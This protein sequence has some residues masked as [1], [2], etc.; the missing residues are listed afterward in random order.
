MSTRQHRRPTVAALRLMFVG[1]LASGCASEARQ[2]EE[3]K[4]TDSVS[5]YEIFLAAY[6][7]GVYADSARREVEAIHFEEAKAENSLSGYETFLNLYPDGVYADSARHQIV[8][9]HFEEA[10]AASSIAGFHMFLALYPEG[11]HAERARQLL[12]PLYKAR[13]ERLFSISE[14][15]YLNRPGKPR[16]LYTHVPT[17]GSNVLRNKDVAWMNLVVDEETGREQLVFTD[18]A[19]GD[20]IH[21]TDLDAKGRL[22]DP[23][24]LCLD[25][26][27]NVLR[28]AGKPVLVKPF[29]VE[30]LRKR[31]SMMSFVDY[32]PYGRPAKRT[33]AVWPCVNCSAQTGIADCAYVWYSMVGSQ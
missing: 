17:P 16:L 22:K 20:V 13:A 31:G 6:P 7:E 4:A 11:K 14:V 27:G 21:R 1:L 9:I 29:E 23:M 26:G 19:S 18:A 2:W 15:V 30:V 25:E 10:R 28:K 12:E 8:A 5:A 24:M 32:D 33:D 3:A